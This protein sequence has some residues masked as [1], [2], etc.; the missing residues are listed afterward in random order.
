MAPAKA[1]SYR[2]PAADTPWLGV[3]EP[4]QAKLWRERCLGMYRQLH[5]HPELSGRE[6][7]TARVVAGRLRS[8]GFTVHEGVG[9]TGVVGKLANGAGPT[10]L[11][12]AELDG[13]AVAE[14]T[15]LPYASN[16]RAQLDGS[17]Q[18]ISHACGHDVHMAALL[19]AA[20]KL[21]AHR[22]Q[23]SGT[24]VALFQPAE[25]TGL[26]AQAM[27]DDR[28]QD[29]I[30]CP[31]VLLAQHSS[32]MPAG[33]VTMRSGPVTAAGTNLDVTFSA[34]SGHVALARKVENPAQA[35]GKLMALLEELT[36]QSAQLHHA[37]GKLWAGSGYNIV[38]ETAGLGL[39]LRATDDE[40]LRQLVHGL[41]HAAAEAAAL[42]TQGRVPQ[43]RTRGYFPVLCN[44]LEATAQVHQALQRLD[45]PVY[46]Q[47]EQAWACEDLG[48]LARGLRTPAVYWFLGVSDPVLFSEADRARML[49][50]GI[51]QQVPANHS[52]NFAPHL[53]AVLHGAIAM[54]TAALAFFKEVS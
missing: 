40:R 41:R 23:W 15:G 33:V 18:G 31:R 54:E 16:A 35:V 17:E 7:R 46:W 4:E 34:V 1:E 43:I 27:L 11:M 39:S 5:Q 37:V 28:L 20:E 42:H 44:D 32:P 48:V 29:L 21:A 47:V 38:P 6:Y 19:A 3:R 49:E 12:R 9:G 10:V 45:F 22:R 30:G 14:Q 36:G 8:L 51:P 13:L 25:E 26:G 53:E 24:A 50:G 52:G 2:V